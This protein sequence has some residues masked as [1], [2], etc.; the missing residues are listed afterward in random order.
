MRSQ[1]SA[2]FYQQSLIKNTAAQQ[3][4]DIVPTGLQKDRS[5]D[6]SEEGEVMPVCPVSLLK[7]V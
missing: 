2:L 3:I 6:Y 5:Y 1:F 7:L 4:L